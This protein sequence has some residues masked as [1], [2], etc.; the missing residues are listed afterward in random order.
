MA[1]VATPP[2]ILEGFGFGAG[3]SYI[4]SPIP[5][6]SQQP[7]PRA[8]YT[9]GFPPQTVGATATAPPDVRDF[10]GILFAATQ[11]IAA[12][13]A[14]QYHLFDSS[15]ATKNSGYVLGAIIATADGSGYWLNETNGNSN[16]P[17]T[18]AASSS[19]WVPIAQYGLTAIT[20]LTN[21]NI[22]LTAPQAAKTLITLSGT[23]T[24]NIQIIFPTWKMSWAIQNNTTGAFSVTCKTASGTG[25][26]LSSGSNQIFGDGTNI[27]QQSGAPAGSAV[28]TSSGNFTAVKTGPHLIIGIGGGGG[29]GGGGGASGAVNYAGG[30][31]QGGTGGVL[32][33]VIANLTANTVYP[34]TIGA[35]GNGGSGGSSGASGTVGGNGAATAFSSLLSCVGGLGGNLGI[36]EA[37]EGS[38]TISDNAGNG[39]GFGGGRGGAGVRAAHGNAGAAAT[40]PGG[41]GGGGSGGHSTGTAEA[42]GNGGNGAPGILLMIW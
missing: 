8:S 16:D 17:D 35:A 29:G 5:F 32:N 11:N 7:N 33:A 15:I 37:Y 27:N 10:N 12:L 28:F 13:L 34:V 42:G 41:G 31:G 24:G 2:V 3:S 18:T 6:S 40:G 25:V 39:G 22:T 23:L 1:G 19:G 4:T 21:A 36:Y 38:A 14:G 9:D 26:I 30:S 20:G